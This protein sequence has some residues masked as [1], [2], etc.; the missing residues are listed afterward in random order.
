L[1]SNGQRVQALIVNRIHPAFGDE[2]PAGLRTTAEALRLDQSDAA[3]RQ[4]VLYDNLAD[5]REVALLEREHIEGLRD[6]IGSAVVAY[7]P[8]LAHDVYDFDVLHEIGDMLLG[9]DTLAAQ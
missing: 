8:Y 4:A 5:F 1:A 3:N 6:K 7:V 2:S 9:S